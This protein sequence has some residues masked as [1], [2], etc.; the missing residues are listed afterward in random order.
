[1]WW[2]DIEKDTRYGCSFLYIIQWFKS[3]VVYSY[4]RW[5]PSL[6]GV[7]LKP[8]SFAGHE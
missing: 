6:Y 5:N 3:S 7:R 8:M 1:V 4:S 2:N